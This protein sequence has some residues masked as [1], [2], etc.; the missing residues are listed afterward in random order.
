[1]WCAWMLCAALPV[2][3]WCSCALSSTGTHCFQNFVLDYFFLL[4]YFSLDFSFLKVLEYDTTY[5][6][7]ILEILD[8]PILH[9]FQV[10]KIEEIQG[11]IR[12]AQVHFITCNAAAPSPSP[13]HIEMTYHA[14][15]AFS[16]FF[17]TICVVTI[18]AAGGT[19]QK[20]NINRVEDALLCNNVGSRS[21]KEDSCYISDKKNELAPCDSRIIA[22]EE[23]LGAEV[24]IVQQSSKI[25]ALTT[26]QKQQITDLFIHSDFNNSVRRLH[27]TY[28]LN[29]HEAATDLL[30][31]L[32]TPRPWL[33]VRAQTFPWLYEKD[34]SG[35][36]SLSMTIDKYNIKFEPYLRAVGAIHYPVDKSF[37]DK[38]AHIIGR[39][40]GTHPGW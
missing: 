40:S 25:G 14:L 16:L 39:N 21:K 36:K 4:F 33:F 24:I 1:M 7:A 11:K 17:S 9:K 38:T 5:V 37:C 3:Y 6:D 26:E 18:E 23:C 13:S 20:W 8:V 30:D 22:P 35:A 32:L 29:T 2:L 27:I 12:C 28:P 31:E 34:P 19:R 15:L 10:F